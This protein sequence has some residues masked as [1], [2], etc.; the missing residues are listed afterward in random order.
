[1][2]KKNNKKEIPL[3]V[4]NI[5]FQSIK[6]QKTRN[7]WNTNISKTRHHNWYWNMVMQ[8]YIIIGIFSTIRLYCI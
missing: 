7:R 8:Y 6:K 5:N 2:C 4:L 3:K 1:M